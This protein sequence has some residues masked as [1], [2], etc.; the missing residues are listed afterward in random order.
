MRKEQVRRMEA[1]EVVQHTLLAISFTV[2]VVTGFSLRFYD[3][4]WARWIFG[5]EGGAQI[6]GL[7][8]RGS[9]HR[10]DRR[11]PSGT[12]GYLM[13]TQ[14]PHLPEGHRAHMDWTPSR[15]GV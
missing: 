11:A 12:W 4:W 13:T 7:I 9:G 14:G 10:H 2:L 15:P 6:R 1:D 5:H 8:H 3:A